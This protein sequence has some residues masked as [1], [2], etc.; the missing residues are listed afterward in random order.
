MIAILGTVV[1]WALGGA[2]GALL[3][4]GGISLVVFSGLSLAV[5][6][7]ME[8]AADSLAGAPA[9]VVQL[10][11][12]TGVGDAL[13]LIGAALITRAGILAA[14]TALGFRKVA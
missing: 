2:L 4:G 13:S 1:Q 8:F 14:G 10:A 5:E 6:S 11:L 7:A 12:L 9:D 3:V